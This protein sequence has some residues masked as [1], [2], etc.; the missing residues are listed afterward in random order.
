MDGATLLISL[1]HFGARTNPSIVTLFVQQTIFDVILN[2]A[3]FQAGGE[4]L[5]DS[6]VI[7]WV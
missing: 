3:L 5:K 7:I 1:D 6:I 4:V 2:R